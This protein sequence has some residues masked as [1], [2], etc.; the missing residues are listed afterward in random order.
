M[1][2]AEKLGRVWLKNGSIAFAAT[3]QGSN[4]SIATVKVHSIWSC[5]LKIL[6]FL[7]L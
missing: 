7:I 1:E 3:S 6:I 2:A 4:H 5:L